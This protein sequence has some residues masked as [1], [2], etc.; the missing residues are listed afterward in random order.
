MCIRDSSYT[1]ALMEIG[2]RD[3]PNQMGADAPVNPPAPPGSVSYAGN[4]GVGAPASSDFRDEAR[5][6]IDWLMKMWDDKTKTLYYQ[7][8]NTQDW[9]YYGY[10]DPD[11]YK[12]Q[13]STNTGNRRPSSRERPC[14]LQ[15]GL[16][17]RL[18]SNR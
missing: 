18:S 11:V 14:P 6:G 17:S 13:P 12:R 5:F 8:D 4:I 9:D 1:T 15:V 16:A 3:F 10:G 2:I 7:V